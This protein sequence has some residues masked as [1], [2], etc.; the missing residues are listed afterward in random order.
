MTELTFSFWFH[1][2]LLSISFFYASLIL[3]F[4]V[5]FKTKKHAKN[6]SF[7]PEISLIVAFRNE[8][9]NLNALLQSVQNQNYPLAKIE[10]ILVNDSSTDQSTEIIKL[11]QKNKPYLRIQLLHLNTEKPGVYGKKEAL[12]LAY[13]RAKA[14]YVLQ[15][16]ADC[17]FEPDNIQ[18]RVEGFLN[19]DIKMVLA[20]VLIKS[21]KNLFFQAQALENISLMASTAA[22]VKAGIPLMSNGANLAFKRSVLEEISENALYTKERSGDD[23]FLM[24]Q[25]KARFGN[26]SI[27]FA[28]SPK[29]AVYTPAQKD[30][31]SFFYQ[32][33]RWVSKSKSYT[34]TWLIIVSV[35]VLL[36]N[37]LITGTAFSLFFTQKMLFVFVFSLSLKTIVDFLFL[38]KASLWYRQ[39]GVLKVYPVLLL[40]YPVFIV[41]SALLG[42][43]L[44]YTW[45]GRSN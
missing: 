26:S 21:E 25:I 39:T 1:F 28:F 10:L 32:R 18:T 36:V 20:P 22:S 3:W 2:F 38:L 40:F 29:A 17:F 37:L 16:D 34:D 8:E 42:N 7:Q 30:L 14:P 44:P 23:L 35:L 19:P 15:T 45:K 5:A 4:F 12:I 13:S 43:F 41:F 31:K 6:T 9:K 24:Q 33:I 27:A 11:F